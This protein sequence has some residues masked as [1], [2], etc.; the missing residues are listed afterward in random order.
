MFLPNIKGLDVDCRQNE[1][2]VWVMRINSTGIPPHKFINPTWSPSGGV[3][4]QAYSVDLPMPGTVTANKT[5]SLTKQDACNFRATFS[6]GSIPEKPQDPLFFP[7]VGFALNGIPFMSPLAAPVHLDPVFPGHTKTG[8]TGEPEKLDGC[9][10]HPQGAG[11][12]HYHMMPPCLFGS[13]SEGD[14]PLQKAGDPRTLGLAGFEKKLTV[15][16]FAMDGFPVYGPYDDSGSLHTGLDN[17]N[18]KFD[19]AGDYGYYSTTTFPYHIGCFG[20]GQPVTS[21][22]YYCSANPRTQ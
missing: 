10:G 19:A 17:C 21:G 12:Y 8:Q 4:E 2:N 18:G 20:P 1:N 11:V 15:I 9:I 5:R 14:T 3:K 16:G 13:D 6:T 22:E 7:I